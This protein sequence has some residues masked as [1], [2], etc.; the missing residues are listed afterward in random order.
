MGGVSVGGVQRAGDG[1]LEFAGS[2]SLENNG[3]FSS[4][5]SRGPA[6][7]LSEFDGLVVRLRGDGRKYSLSVR[8]DLPIPAGAYY[9]DVE[10]REGEWQEIHVPFESFAAR[11]FGRAAPLA[12]RLNRSDVR[13]VGFIIADKREGPFRLNIDWIKAAAMAD[14]Q[15]RG[16]GQLPAQ[17]RPIARNREGPG[18]ESA[19]GPVEPGA[20][21]G[22]VMGTSSF[23][24][25][26]CWR[27]G[28]S[29]YDA[30]VVKPRSG[31]PC[32]GRRHEANS[33]QV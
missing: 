7:D 26:P 13:S 18:R 20:L 3:G 5:R 4:V 10:T 1:K 15:A 16:E 23:R 30:V 14:K 28:F 32:G 27:L 17:G 24:H 12:S 22:K 2:L 8:T 31:G 9:F 25:F 11:S 19:P 29:A 6:L 21:P 33:D